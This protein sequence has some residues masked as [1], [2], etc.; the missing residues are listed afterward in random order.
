LYQKN[1]THFKSVLKSK[2][3]Q[4][5]DLDKNIEVVYNN[6]T[7]IYSTKIYSKPSSNG[8]LS[9]EEDDITKS[10]SS[11]MI[12]EIVIIKEATGDGNS[13]GGDNSD[14]DSDE[15]WWYN[16]DDKEDASSGEGGGGG[17]SSGGDTAVT[18]PED[19]IIIDKTFE[20][21][22]CVKSI[23]DKLKGTITGGKYFKMFDNST[24]VNVNF[25]L[26]SLPS[27]KFGVTNYNESTKNYDITICQNKLD[28]PMVSIAGTII[29]ET[30]HAGIEAGL[31]QR[32]TKFIKDNPEF[33]EVWEAQLKLPSNEKENNLQKIH[34]NHMANRYLNTIKD[35]MEEY[36]GQSTTYTQDELIALAWSGLQ[37][38]TTYNE[39]SAQEKRKITQNQSSAYSKGTRYNCR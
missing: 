9:I 21:N 26:G 20:D 30:L 6:K 23:Y 22:E 17:S 16:R 27:T 5:V 37:G 29:H 15:D 1:V 35:A 25:K 39:L 10:A 13:G 32:G 14:E 24:A 19:K 7:I 33:T 8:D 38:T 2:I 12:D 11:N 4:K 3:K 28:R 18:T 31:K 36:M 34:H